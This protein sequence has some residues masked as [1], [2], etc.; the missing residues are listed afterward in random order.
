[1][2]SVYQNLSELPHFRCLGAAASDAIAEAEAELGLS[3][4]KDYRSYLEACS[5]A[6]VNGHE[7][8]GICKSPRLDVV[9]VT[10]KEREKWPDIDPRWYVLE[11]TGMDGVVAWQSA[12][13]VVYLSIPESGYVVACDSLVEYARR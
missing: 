6:S 11:R 12:D 8:T 5:F 9:N 7:F 1:M 2:R 3:F 10:R 4:A 13:G